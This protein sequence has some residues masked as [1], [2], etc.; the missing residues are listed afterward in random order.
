[1]TPVTLEMNTPILSVQMMD[2]DQAQ[3]AAQKKQTSQQLLQERQRIGQLA[4]ALDKAISSFNQLNEEILMSHKEQIVRLSVDIASRI[5]AK[6]VSQRNYEIEKII[7]EALQTVP[8]SQQITIRMNPDDLKAWQ[9]AVN[10]DK[11]KA[12]ENAQFIGDWGINNAECIVE[13]DSGI[14]EYLIDEHL[15]QIASALTGPEVATEQ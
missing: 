7:T 3:Q 6:D 14:V 9:E 13:T 8:A 2:A 1:M 11:V 10:E 4:N 12:P 5:L 15:K